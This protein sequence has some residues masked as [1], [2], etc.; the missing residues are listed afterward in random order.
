MGR[1]PFCSALESTNFV[2]AIGPSCASTNS[3][4]PSTMSSTRSTSPPKSAW[5]GV[6][7]ALNTQS[8][9][10]NDVYLELM[11]MPRSF[12]R[13]L[14]SMRRSEA[15]CPPWFI[16]VSSSVVLPWSTC[17]MMAKLRTPVADSAEGGASASSADRAADVEAV[18][19]RCRS[20]GDQWVPAVERSTS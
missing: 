18:N 19:Q 17:A 12:S 2:C 1:R 3:R 8:R 14:L 20:G 7:T 16:S 9:Q 6:S 15:F 13:A 4:H 11:V 5:P 10:G